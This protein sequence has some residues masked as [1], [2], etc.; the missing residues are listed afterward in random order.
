MSL[1]YKTLGIPGSIDEV[2]D[3][4]QKKNVN[5]TIINI[6]KTQSD[7]KITLQVA[8]ELEH[9]RVLSYQRYVIGQKV[10]GLN[11]GFHKVDEYE[12]SYQ[13]ILNEAK[14]ARDYLQEKGISA[15]I[16]FKR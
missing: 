11:F 1:L 2:V 16:L 4:L 3:L 5:H 8:V 10:V 12:N 7:D 9:Q 13:E 14:K 15:M 6:T